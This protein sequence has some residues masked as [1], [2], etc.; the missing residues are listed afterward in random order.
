MTACLRGRAV[1]DREIH[2][3]RSLKTN[4]QRFEGNMA[5]SAWLCGFCGFVVTPPPCMW[6]IQDRGLG[7]RI[8]HGDT[9]EQGDQDMVVGSRKRVAPTPIRKISL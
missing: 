7:C 2:P 3:G 6:P 5:T 4:D 1:G 9:K 8:S